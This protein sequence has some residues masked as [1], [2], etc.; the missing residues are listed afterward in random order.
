MGFAGDNCVAIFKDV[1]FKD[2]VFLGFCFFKDFV[3][4]SDIQGMRLYL[5]S[6]ICMYTLCCGYVTV[7]PISRWLGRERV[8]PHSPATEALLYLEQLGLS[9]RERRQVP[10]SLRLLLLLLLLRL[11]HQP[12][13]ARRRRRP[14]CWLGHAVY[15][16]YGHRCC[17][18]AACTQGGRVA[19]GERGRVRGG[20]GGGEGKGR[21]RGRRQGG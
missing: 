5:H 12:P 18:F 19:R 14:P 6:F 21:G 20:G 17:V 9:A 7:A 2:F 16:L 4:R 3:F 15:G 10:T 13:S 1:E 11:H 8:L